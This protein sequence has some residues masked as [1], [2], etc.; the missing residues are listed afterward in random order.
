M[1]VV[2]VPRLVGGLIESGGISLSLRDTL[3]HLPAELAGVPLKDIF[4]GRTLRADDRG[5]A[6]TL[7][8]GA[9]LRDFPVALLEK[10][11]ND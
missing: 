3:I 11:A 2:I 8:A 1:V 9:A 10:A 7:S 6:V 5:G 4:T